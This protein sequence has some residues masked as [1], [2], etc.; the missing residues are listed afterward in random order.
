MK[1]K[2]RKVVGRPRKFDQDAALEQ[3]MR[4][5]WRHGYEGVSLDQLTA[6]MGIAPP[7]LYGAFG[8]KAELYRAAL[9]RYGSLDLSAM[10]EAQ[11]L[12]G[13]V[14][15]LLDSAIAAITDPARERGCMVS[16]G[17]V[18]V[19][20]LHQPQAVETAMR[21]ALLR[22]ELVQA[23]R[24]FFEIDAASS[25]GLHLSAVLTGL[26]VQARDGVPREA[27]NLVME[28]VVA[29]LAAQFTENIITQD[30]P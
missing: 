20:P 5:F 23:L 22:T 15:A 14:R 25:L 8:S 27:L 29:G 3:A 1:L 6:A 18:A 10:R 21:R 24:P 13:A 30:Q 19:H 11:T 26:S 9:D 17:L 12:A 2:T 16:S 28:S 7:S 4:L